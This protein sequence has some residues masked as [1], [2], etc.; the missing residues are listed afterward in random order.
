[1]PKEI[2][3]SSYECDC[4]HQSHFFENTIREIKAASMRK[5][6]HLADSER[7]E[8]T[9]VFHKGRMVDILCP[10]QE[11]KSSISQTAKKRAERSG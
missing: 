10:K 11:Q 2:D 3:Y 6:V 9:I 5:K 1:M 4:G 7:E 8:H